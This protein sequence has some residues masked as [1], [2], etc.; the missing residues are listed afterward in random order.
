MGLLSLQPLWTNILRLSPVCFRGPLAPPRHHTV[1]QTDQERLYAAMH[2]SGA[3]GGLEIRS[4][5]LPPHRLPLL[6]ELNI[7]FKRVG[8]NFIQKQ[9]PEAK[10]KELQQS[11][12]QL[13]TANHFSNSKTQTREGR[14]HTSPRWSRSFRRLSAQSDP[15]AASGCGSW[16]RVPQWG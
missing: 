2:S 5:L 12:H 8:R 1:Q 6:L 14:R 16:E 4:L 9:V 13:G 11:C 7:Y 10:K 3:E 15:F